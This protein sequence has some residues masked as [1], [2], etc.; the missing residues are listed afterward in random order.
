Q[1]AATTPQRQPAST[2]AAPTTQRTAPATAPASTP[3][4]TTQRQTPPATTPANGAVTGIDLTTDNQ[5]AT[6]SS[7][8]ANGVAVVRRE[9]AGPDQSARKA[10]VSGRAERKPGLRRKDNG[11]LRVYYRRRGLF[12][13]EGHRLRRSRRVAASTRIP[14]PTPQTRSLS[15]RRSGHDEPVSTRRSLRH[16]RWR[17][18]RS[19]SRPLRTLHRCER[20]ARR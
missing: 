8:S 2:G 11:S 17:R 14:G 20:H 5:L 10:Q 4:A 3:P 15:Q 1:T 13:W 19:G 16:R 6:E 9:R 7:D 18:N 12:S